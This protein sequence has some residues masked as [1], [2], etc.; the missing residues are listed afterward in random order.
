MTFQTFNHWLNEWHSIHSS[1]RYILPEL[2]KTSQLFRKINKNN[3]VGLVHS[4]VA[5]V[6]S[7]IKEQTRL[8]LCVL[9]K[10]LMFEEKP[11]R[12]SDVSQSNCLTR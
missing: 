5:Y 1:A 3:G 10:T 2:A 8:L 7:P 4:G 6:Y 9:M 12:F 11:L